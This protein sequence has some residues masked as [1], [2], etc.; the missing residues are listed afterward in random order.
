MSNINNLAK[1]AN[2][3]EISTQAG[4]AKDILDKILNDPSLAKGYKKILKDASDALTYIHYENCFP[5][6]IKELQGI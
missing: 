6:V 4:I 3:I 1:V 2:A 5:S